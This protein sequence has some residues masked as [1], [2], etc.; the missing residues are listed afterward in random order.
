MH[1]YQYMAHNENDPKSTPVPQLVYED[2]NF[3]C[4]HRLHE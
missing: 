2:V 4:R 1:I 3:W